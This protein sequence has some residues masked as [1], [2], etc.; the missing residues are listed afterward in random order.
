M[1]QFQAHAWAAAAD[2][3]GV[4]D[5]ARPGQ[6]TA[7]LYR[8]KALTNLGRFDDAATALQAFIS[9]HP[10]SDD[11]LYSLAYVRFRQNQAR[12]SL[13]LFNRGAQLKPPTADDL[14][15]VALDYVL[16]RDYN[17]AVRYLEESLKLNPDNLEARYHLGRARYQ[18]NQFDLAIAAF[19]QVLLVDPGNI[20]AEDNLGLSYEAKNDVDH[21]ITAYRKAI[22]LDQASLTH[23]AQPYLNLGSLFARSNRG[24]EAIPLL[25]RAS[26]IDPSSGKAWYE[27]GKAYLNLERPEEARA[28]AETA[29]RLSPD[30]S[31]YHYLLG[32][33]YSRL[34]KTELSARQFKATEDL[35]KRK[36]NAMAEVPA[37]Q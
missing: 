14:K 21:A 27:L 8:G 17:D 22:Q 13:Q 32:R 30:E 35:I 4:C 10:S 18:L 15:I 25:K 26:E 31:S 1:K 34:G 23:N 12:E 37:S 29:V 28:A 9:Q 5:R 24:S 11:G 3:F 36:G 2:A 20:K 19:L 33:I 7:L 6:T 16:L